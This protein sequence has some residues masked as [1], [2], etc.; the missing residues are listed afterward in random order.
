MSVFDREPSTAQMLER[1]KDQPPQMFSIAWNGYLSIAR[2][3]LYFFATTSTD[4]S[5][6]YI[7][8]QL[9]VDNTGGHE[10]G[11]AGSIQLDEGP[12]R[13]LLEYVHAGGRPGLKWEWVYFGDSD[14]AY[15]VV[16]SWALSRQPVSSA[17]VSVGRILDVM[18]AASTI[19]LVL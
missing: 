3:G 7:D 12:H 14:K 1:W 15:Q 2:P 17:T 6:L 4:R 13:V 16:P 5:R 18:R 9:V 8:N 11:Q 10:N 19:L